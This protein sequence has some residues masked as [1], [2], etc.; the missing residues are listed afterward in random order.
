LAVLA[1]GDFHLNVGILVEGTKGNATFG[2][3]K[4]DVLQLRENSASA[5]DNTTDSNQTVKM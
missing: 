3:V 2:T 1:E 5:G 4:L